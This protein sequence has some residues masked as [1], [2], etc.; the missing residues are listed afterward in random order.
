MRY[1]IVR[2][3]A[4]AA[5]AVGCL[6]TGGGVAHAAPAEPDGLHAPSALVLTIGR[7]ETAATAAVQRAVVLHCT[8][9]AFGSHPAPRKA[10]AELRAVDGE[11][12]ALPGATGEAPEVMCTKIWDPVVVTAEGVWEG[13]RVSYERS[14]PN[15][16]VLSGAAGPVFDF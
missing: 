13:S 12:A 6:A 4:A 1:S 7:G 3:G 8:P 11:F 14:Y 15:S 9:V 2:W 5:L 10:C 16:C